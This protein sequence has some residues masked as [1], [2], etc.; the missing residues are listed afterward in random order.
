MHVLVARLFVSFNNVTSFDSCATIHISIVF[1][2]LN[3]EIKWKKKKRVKYLFHGK[4]KYY[5]DKKK[6]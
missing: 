3:L 2:M 5:P 6:S 4:Y 1:S